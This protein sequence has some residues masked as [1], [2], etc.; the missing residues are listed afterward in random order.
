MNRER[1]KRGGL[2]R[3]GLAVAFVGV[4]LSL[5]GMTASPAGAEKP[6][7]IK[8]TLC[9]RTNSPTNPYRVVEVAVDATNGEIVGPDHTGHE[10]PAFDFSAVLPPD[11]TSPYSSPRNGDQ[12][13]DI[14]PPYEFANGSFPGMNW[15]DGADIHAADCQGPEGD[16]EPD[17]EC[18]SGQVWD[19][20]NDDEIFDLDECI[21]EVPCPEGTEFVDENGN[22]FEE[23]GECVEPN[24]FACPVGTDGADD[25]EN[26]VVDDGECVAPTAPPDEEVLGAVI[27]PPVAQALPK[28][29][30]ST[31][32]LTAAGL[33]LI[34]IGAGALLIAQP[35]K[36]T[37]KG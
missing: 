14:I 32:P 1:T 37:I 6:F 23:E 5:T 29:G 31:G 33:G 26:G 35:K 24:V 34:L 4:I 12:W 21:T 18:P 30:T 8:I 7:T 17:P 9:H 2:F 19:D 36:A 10:G 20:A 15:E 22:G 3:A 13:G 25:N 16:P 27:T 11:P 28:T